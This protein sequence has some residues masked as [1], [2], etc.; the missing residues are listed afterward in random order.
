MK[1]FYIT[2]LSV[3]AVMA[4]FAVVF[5]NLSFTQLSAILLIGAIGEYLV[6]VAYLSLPCFETRRRHKLERR[7]LEEATK[8]LNSGS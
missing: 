5:K 4:V 1:S 2:W 8:R 3:V 7:L 6:R